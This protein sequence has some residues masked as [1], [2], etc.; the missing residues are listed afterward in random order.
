[1]PWP[2]EGGR[3]PRKIL[4]KEHVVEQARSHGGTPCFT[5]YSTDA[6]NKERPLFCL[7]IEDTRPE[8]GDAGTIRTLA[9]KIQEGTEAAR[10]ETK[11][12]VDHDRIEVVGLPLPRD[13]SNEQRFIACQAHQL[14]EIAARK[15]TRKAD[16]YILATQHNYDYWHAF[17]ILVHLGEGWESE[18]LDRL[19]TN[20]KEL[21]TENAREWQRV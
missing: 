20:P 3:L 10:C 16:F 18:A 17:V 15:A 12:A 7:R 5:A 1:M 8:A 14:V 9:V 11:P 4:L 19:A 13:A 2:E 21:V 6:E